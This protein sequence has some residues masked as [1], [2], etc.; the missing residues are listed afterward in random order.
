MLL[1]LLHVSGIQELTRI[2]ISLVAVVQPKLRRVQPCI[3]TRIEPVLPHLGVELL[4]LHAA[5][6]GILGKSLLCLVIL[7]VHLTGDVGHLLACRLLLKLHLLLKSG[8]AKRP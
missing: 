2:L 6:Q 7:H 4:R 1:L 5:V 3:L 8:I